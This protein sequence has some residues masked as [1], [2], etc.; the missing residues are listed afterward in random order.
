MNEGGDK[1]TPRAKVD[2]AK[3]EQQIVALKLRG[4]A[5]P[6][7]ARVI[8]ISRQAVHRA[9]DKALRRQTEAALDAWHRTEL[10]GLAMEATN[11]W[12]L[13][14][15]PENKNNWKAQA[16]LEDRLMRIHI[17][18]AKLLGLDAPTKLD[19]SGIYQRGGAD[20][21]AEQFARDA[22]LEALPIEEQRRLY[23][24]FYQARLRAAA[25][26]LSEPAIETTLSNG[27]DHRND[28]TDT[29]AEPTE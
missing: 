23:D 13:M 5:P 26:N 12:R 4:I 3:R 18:R 25:G 14:D 29:D 7:I 10:G 6:E 21:E 16:A 17:R 22:V 19:V 11:I 1:R 2:I 8:G 9:F 28:V 20:A 27:S 15:L 24:I